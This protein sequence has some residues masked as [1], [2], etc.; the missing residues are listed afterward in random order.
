MKITTWRLTRS[1][2][3][4]KTESSCGRLKSWSRRIRRLWRCWRRVIGRT[5]SS[6]S[7]WELPTRSWIGNK[8]KLVDCLNSRREEIDITHKT[9][10]NSN[11]N[12]PPTPKF[13]PKWNS[14]CRS[15]K[16]CSPARLNKSNS[17]CNS[18][19]YLK[20][21]FTNFKIHSLQKLTHLLK[22]FSPA[23]NKL[24]QY[25]R[26]YENIKILRVWWVPRFNSWKIKINQEIRWRSSMRMLWWSWMNISRILKAWRVNCL[27]WEVQRMSL[28]NWRAR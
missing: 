17:S 19:T 22:I 8:N 11:N 27:S 3:K 7:N 21:K 13:S 14:R 20:H 15:T 9:H 18:Y 25:A 16:T 6:R 12:W 23:I 1:S 24:N 10:K 4:N 2:W 26:L 28:N 5:K